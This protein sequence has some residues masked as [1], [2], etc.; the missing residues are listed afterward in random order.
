MSMICIAR[1]YGE[2]KHAA[3]ADEGALGMWG[4]HR[5]VP[6]AGIVAGLVAMAQARPERSDPLRSVMTSLGFTGGEYCP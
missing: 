2:S 6:Q 5:G 4:Y 3:P 1:W